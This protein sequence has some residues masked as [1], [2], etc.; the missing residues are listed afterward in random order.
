MIDGPR[1]AAI[2][3]LIG[4]PARAN[5]LTALLD[6]RALTASELAEAGGIAPPTASGHLSR[7]V[8]AGLMAVRRQ[9][10]HRYFRLSGS[11]VAE[12]LERLMG[13]AQRT[14]ALP[15]RTGPRDAALR[16]ARICYDHLAG[17][18]GVA[19]LDSFRRRGFVE[20]EEEIAVTPA[21]R[22]F[23]IGLGLDLGALAKGRR[24]LCRACLD[25]S[26]RR[27]HLGGALGAV[28]LDLLLDRQWLGRGHGRELRFSPTGL[29]DFATEFA[30]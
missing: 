2:A 3:A 5:M 20:G 30:G 7:L 17:A 28:L 10:R 14:G 1:I 15:V 23:F 22:A 19:M 6:G 29:R 16:E 8:D 4:D 18:K 21:G 9:G 27:A 24:P 13:L 26:E 11:D 12:A 25:W